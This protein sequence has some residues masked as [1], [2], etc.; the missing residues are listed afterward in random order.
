VRRHYDVVIFTINWGPDVG[1]FGS[2]VDLA[3]RLLN[4]ADQAKQ[5]SV[6]RDC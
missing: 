1:A 5:L 6:G 4:H 2:A 3:R